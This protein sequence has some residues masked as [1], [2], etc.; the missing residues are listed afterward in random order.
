M[1]NRMT[2]GRVVYLGFVCASI[3]AF[4]MQAVAVYTANMPRALLRSAL[5]YRYCL[6]LSERG[7]YTALGCL[8]GSVFIGW[9]DPASEDG[10]P[11]RTLWLIVLNV[12]TIALSL[13]FPML[14]AL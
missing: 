13:F 9:I 14:A 1:R 12:L 4:G 8:I 5:T 7:F 6:Q 2:F 11:K 3:F 10:K